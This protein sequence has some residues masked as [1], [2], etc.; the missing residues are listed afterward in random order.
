M[1]SPPLDKL[2]KYE[3]RGVLGR[4]AAGTVYEAW[5]PAMERKVAVKTVR[6]PPPMEAQDE[7]ARCRREAQAA[8]RLSHSGIV[9]AYDYGETDGLAYIVMEFVDGRTLKSALEA[10]ERLSVPA[11]LRVMDDVLAALD[12]SH[13]RG[14]VHRDI[15]PANVILTAE[16]RTKVADF[17]I[18]RIESSNLTQAG[19]VMGTPAYMSPEQ[20]MGQ[21]VDR[22]TD[23][24]ACGV[25]LY[26]LL[27]GER[28]FEGSL[29]GIMHKALN[30]VPPRPSE[31]TVTAPAALD[32]VVAR[33]MAKRPED[34]YRSAAEF[35]RAIRQAVSVSAQDETVV[36]SPPSRPAPARSWRFRLLALGTAG[37]TAGLGTASWLLLASDQ[38]TKEPGPS[39]PPSQHLNTLSRPSSTPSSPP[40]Q[41][42]QQSA[43]ESPAPQP[44]PQAVS[45]PQ[46]QPG[47]QPPQAG[48]VPQDHVQVQET[49]PTRLPEPQMDRV[50]DAQPRT[51]PPESSPVPIPAPGSEMQGGLVRPRP[52][53]EPS[54]A[55]PQDP[56]DG[57]RAAVAEALGSIPCALLGGSLSGAGEL[58]LTGLARK[59]AE[60]AIRAAVARA[61]PGYR[62]AWS[63]V[64]FEGARLCPALDVLRPVAGRFGAPNGLAVGTADGRTQYRENENVVM[65][66]EMPGFPAWL[67]ADYLAGDGTVSHV[68]PS[69]QGHAPQHLQAS[70]RV[71]VG[72]T[73]EGFIDLPVKDP[74][75][76]DLVIFVASAMPLFEGKR[77]DVEPAASYLRD[78]HTA[79][80]AARRDGSPVAAA[81][82]V[83]KT[84]PAQR[85]APVPRR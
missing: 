10:E 23:I 33:A 13:G 84:S 1:E 53:P 69:S 72:D 63:V 31:L 50:L 29:T 15:K 6:L 56:R 70:T 46:T 75:G 38:Q 49:A 8:G 44:S 16:G 25:L 79:L 37:L 24:Y 73:A 2:G 57:L 9:A 60:P 41:N 54:V 3:L 39:A 83:L 61:A 74:F 55:P 78:L 81:A 5:D 67:R 19:T 51:A 7:L 14:V 28:P 66:V 42:A 52:L 27:A 36:L 65:P 68:H 35:A 21:V 40:N 82:L 34:R 22:R 85:S 71:R 48:P 45:P 59:D 12:Y 4:G 77:P 18:A 64:P 32:A 30:T 80:D 58:R 47:P 11:V 62:I 26:Q 20:F 17:G 43:R 76:T